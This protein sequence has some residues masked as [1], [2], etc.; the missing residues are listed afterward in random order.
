[1]LAAQGM[2]QMHKDLGI[3]A[4]LSNSMP[5]EETGPQPLALEA[6]Q[7]SELWL[8]KNIGWIEDVTPS[9]LTELEGRGIVAI[10]VCKQGFSN[11]STLWYFY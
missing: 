1:M 4:C 6:S 9:P 3:T 10:T 7:P 2:D 5:E 11:Y 8:A